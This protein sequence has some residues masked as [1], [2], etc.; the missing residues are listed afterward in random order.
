MLKILFNKVKNKLRKLLL[1][2]KKISYSQAGEDLIL[3]CIFSSVK[4][5]FYIDVGA[6]HPTKSSNTYFFYKKGWT[7]INIDALPDAIKMF[8]K[9]RK[10]D[11]NIEAG[12]SDLE[13]ILNFYSF[14]ESSYNTF[15]EELVDEIK[16]V[17]PLIDVRK[18]AVKP[19]SLI[20]NKLNIKSINF[21]SIDVEGLDI[22]VLKSNDWEKYRPKVLL[23]EDF[24]HGVDIIQSPIYQYMHTLG[25]IYFCQTCTNVFYIEKDFHAQRFVHSNK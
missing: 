4:K 14:K 7:G 19:L 2:D 13:S 5:G 6:N 8:Q 16:K 24:N 1:G 23:V 22:N 17:S 25:Y 21:M 15:N 20:L 11:I 9:K 18:I 3:N 12:V 10:K